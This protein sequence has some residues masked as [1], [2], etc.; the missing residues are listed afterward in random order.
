MHRSAV[1]I[2]SAPCCAW[3]CCEGWLLQPGRR[4]A[5]DRPPRYGKPL[6][7]DLMEVDLW[8]ELPAVFDRV[9]P[10]LLA[11]LL[12]KSL[13]RGDKFHSLIRPEDGEVCTRR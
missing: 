5:L 11:A 9:Q 7:V 12:D 1:C 3:P 2:P 13:L 8:R 6:V 4:C 10:G